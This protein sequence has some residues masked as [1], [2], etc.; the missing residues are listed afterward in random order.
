MDDP[1]I[2]TLTPQTGP[3]EVSQMQASATPNGEC[4]ALTD[5]SLSVP[6]GGV[7]ALLGLNG[8]GKTT[9]FSFRWLPLSG[10]AD[11][12]RRASGCSCVRAVAA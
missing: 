6:R 3:A 1:G 5:V 4:H 10:V 7:A 11:R 8:A 9:L 12:E 2:A